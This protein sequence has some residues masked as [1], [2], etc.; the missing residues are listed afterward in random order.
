MNLKNGVL[1]P[2]NEEQKHVK[3]VT[4]LHCPS[5]LATNDENF[6]HLFMT[7]SQDGLVKIWD[8]RTNQSVA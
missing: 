6:V 3:P 2:L 7:A 5:A 1:T 4:A 8:R